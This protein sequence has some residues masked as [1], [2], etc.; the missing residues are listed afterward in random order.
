MRAPASSCLARSRRLMLCRMLMPRSRHGF[1]ALSR[2]SWLPRVRLATEVHRRL[3]RPR[4]RRQRRCLLLC[5]HPSLPT[6]A[7][8]RLRRPWRRRQRR[9]SRLL[10]RLAAMLRRRRPRR[11]RRRRLRR[12]RSTRRF[13]RRFTLTWA[14]GLA[15]QMSSRVGC[16]LSRC[17]AGAF[18][19]PLGSC[20]GPTGVSSLRSVRMGCG[21]SLAVS[22]SL[23]RSRCKRFLASCVRRS[24]SRCV[25]FLAISFHTTPTAMARLHPS[26]LTSTK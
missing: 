3:R 2:S 1:A 22:S 19:L 23:G 25:A 12:R 4:R 10:M 21:T 11:P 14:L 8:R 24:A 13:L 26:S 5:I 17:T 7:R 9:R 18:Q 15:D 6:A 16:I 20:V